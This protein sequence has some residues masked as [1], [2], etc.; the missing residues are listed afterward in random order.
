MTA[1]RTPLDG[2]CVLATPGPS[3][4]VQCDLGPASRQRPGEPPT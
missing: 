4:A 2:H 1:E 3:N